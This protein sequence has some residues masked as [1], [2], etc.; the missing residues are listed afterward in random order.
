[1]TEQ[2]TQ[3]A[4]KAVRDLLSCFDD[5]QREGLKDTPRRY[6]KFLAEFLKE[7]VFEFTAFDGEKYDEMV[8]VSNIPF[9][10]LCEHHMA[11]FFGTAA[12]AYIPNGKIVGLSKLPRTLQ[13]Y[14]RKLQNQERITMQ[15]AERLQKELSPL[16]VAV[17]I[18]ARHMC[19]EM[20]G[21]KTHDTQTTTC[22]LLGNFKDNGNVRAE[23]FNHIK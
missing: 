2:T 16:G 15:V 19:M 4:E 18:K 7:D 13:H 8:V 10:S 5:P 3:N 6:V 21:V 11:P 17:Q 9:F 23:F 20:R 12:I 14:A 22:T 1:M